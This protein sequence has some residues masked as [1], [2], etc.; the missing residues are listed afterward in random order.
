MNGIQETI[1][2]KILDFFEYFFLY[3]DIIILHGGITMGKNK[4]MLHTF[5]KIL[6]NDEKYIKLIMPK[7]YVK[8]I[9]DI[10]Y[11]QLKKDGYINLIFDIDNTIMPVNDINVDE[12]LYNFFANLKK[13]FNICVLSNNKEWRVNPVKDKLKVNGFPNAKKPSKYALDKA[14][15]LLHS[16]IKNTAMIGD[17][18]LSDIVF[19]NKFGLL[20]ILVESYKNKYDIKTGTSRIL[21]N[22]IM[23][24]LKKQIKRYNYF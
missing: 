9:Y 12:K 8:N 11:Q 18:M 4:D 14:L 2:V 7:H 5:F 22:I 19:A 16:D 23:K 10:D 17:Q 21:Q 3:Y 15:E 1:L 20:P 24:K 13:E 6:K